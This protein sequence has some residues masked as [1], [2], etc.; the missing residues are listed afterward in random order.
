[1]NIQEWAIKHHVSVEALTELQ[2]LFLPE[3]ITEPSN[4]Q[5]EADVVNSVRIQASN[6]GWRLWKNTRGAGHMDNGNYIRFGLANESPQMNRKIKSG[7]LI[8]IRPIKITQMMVGLTIG[9]FVS[10]EVKRPGV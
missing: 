10:R 6:S 9:Q 4:I 5:H 8:G 7:D 2:K 1:M 3:V